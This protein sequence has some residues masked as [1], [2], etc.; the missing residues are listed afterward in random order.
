[1]STG[2]IAIQVVGRIVTFAA[3]A[4]PPAPTAPPDNIKVRQANRLAPTAPPD[5][6][7]VK[8]ANRL[9]PAVPP[10]NIK[11]KQ[12]PPTLRSAKI[13]TPV[14]SVTP[15]PKL[16]L[17]SGLTQGRVQFVRQYEPLPTHIWIG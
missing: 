16:A 12:A 14:K 3:A 6:I 4:R 13:A 9:A 2:V 7:K 15:V 8:Q 10:D 17:V 5:N 11:V 1:M